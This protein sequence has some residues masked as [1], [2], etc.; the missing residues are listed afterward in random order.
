MALLNSMPSAADAL[1]TLLARAC[2]WRSSTLSQVVTEAVS[3]M[4]GLSEAGHRHCKISRHPSACLKNVQGATWQPA[5]ANL[6]SC[7][8]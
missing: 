6:P 3:D 8:D 4:S 2:F 5:L 7:H 1:L